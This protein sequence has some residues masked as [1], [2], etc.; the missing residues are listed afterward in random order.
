MWNFIIERMPGT[1]SII[2]TVLAYLIPYTV[3]KINKTLHKYGDPPWM[4]DEK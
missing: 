4:K 1:L 3:Y 2:C